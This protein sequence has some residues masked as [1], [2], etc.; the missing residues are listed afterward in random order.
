M[1]LYREPFNVGNKGGENLGYNI[2]EE[3]EEQQ[4]HNNKTNHNKVLAGYGYTLNDFGTV[5][6]P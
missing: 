3:E 5:T 2:Y 6:V 4:Q 1:Q